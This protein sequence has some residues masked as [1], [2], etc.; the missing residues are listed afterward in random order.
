[1][2]IARVD[3]F[4]KLWRSGLGLRAVDDDAISCCCGRW[5]RYWGRYQRRIS[6]LFITPSERKSILTSLPGGQ[7]IPS[8]APT[9]PLG[10]DISPSLE[11][12]CISSVGLQRGRRSVMAL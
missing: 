12:A 1:M 7:L 9:V 4:E 8:A 10:V 3:T 6:I 5:F 11:P 2:S